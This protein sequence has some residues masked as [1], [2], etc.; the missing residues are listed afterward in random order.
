MTAFDAADLDGTGLDAALGERPLA[1]LLDVF[2][3]GTVPGQGDEPEGGVTT[4]L[5]EL[6]PPGPT[7]RGRSPDA[8]LAAAYRRFTGAGRPR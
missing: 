3:Q 1:E 4:A 2:W 7:S 6:G 5:D 8:A